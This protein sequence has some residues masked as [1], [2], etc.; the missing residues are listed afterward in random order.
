MHRW[1][2]IFRVF[3]N[4]NKMKIVKLLSEHDKLPVGE[5]TKEIGIS[6]KNTSKHLTELA[7]MGVL[8]AKGKN[9]RVYYS[10]NPKTPK[11]FKQAMK[12]FVR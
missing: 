2:S 11:D 4:I 7:N 9:N 8:M 10:L 1:N 3:A 6:F 12:L 5:I